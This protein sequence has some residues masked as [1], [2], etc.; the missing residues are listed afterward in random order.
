M[1]RPHTL[2]V[3]SGGMDS[4]TL[5]YMAA[6]DGPLTI[7]SFDYGQRHVRE[8]DYAARTAER[9]GAKQIVVPMSWLGPMI[10]GTSAL[11]TQEIEVPDGHYAEETM[12]A[13]V[14]PNRNA[15]MLNV[16]AS[17]AIAVGAQRIGTGVH[18]G[19]HAVYPDCRPEFV[20]A[21]DGML[22]V[23]NEGFL[24]DGWTGIWAPFV[25]VPKDAIAT[26]GDGLGVQWLDTWSC[27]K[28]GEVHC[29]ACGTCFERREAFQLAGVEDPT[30]YL[31]TPEYAE[32]GA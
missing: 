24:P 31:A 2:A 17:V 4:T 15:V 21:L 16:A 14:V 3:V 7:L 20:E 32:P 11:V 10:A 9:L 13:T 18:A 19:D 28:G 26:I 22:R 5:A 23:A 12:R 8:L 27:Y 25:D 29:G 1:T 30:E 6:V